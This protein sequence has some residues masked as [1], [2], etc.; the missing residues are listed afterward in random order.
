MGLDIY[1]CLLS[2]VVGLA[3]CIK[4]F[5]ETDLK[6]DKLLLKNYLAKASHLERIGGFFFFLIFSTFL[7]PS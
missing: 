1:A 7:I 2:I 5:R 4:V 6:Q 3:L